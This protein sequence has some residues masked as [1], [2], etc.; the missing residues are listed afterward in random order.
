MKTLYIGSNTEVIEGLKEYD[1]GNLVFSENGL[2]AINILKKDTEIKAVICQYDLTG[3]D[4][5]YIYNQIR[6]ELKIQNIPFVLLANEHKPQLYKE[7]FDKKIDDYFVIGAT[8]PKNILLRVKQLVRIYKS[9][10]AVKT[11]PDQEKYNYKFPLSKRI[12]DI[13]VASFVLLLLSPLLLIIIIAIRLESKGKVYYIS[14]RVGRKQFD[15]YKLRSMKVGADKLLKELAKEKNQYNAP[16]IK[17]EKRELILCPVCNQYE[18]G[19]QCT[20]FKYD[21]KKQICENLFLKQKELDSKDNSSFIKI[22]D[23]PRITKVGKFIRNTSI[24]ELP[25]LINVLKGDM[26]LVGNRPLPVYEA[27]L[28][29]G[30]NASKRFLAPAGITGLWQVELRGKGGEMSEE[31]RMALDNHYADYFVGKKYSLWFD[32]KILLRTVPALFQKSTV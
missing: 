9:T 28:I 5:I 12:F 22:V 24:D 2:K 17:T 10:N 31:E 4:G 11:I 6:N 21:G 18:E 32:I 3:N 8:E 27:E 14:Q 1:D 30:D 13:V 25:Q 29:T 20:S 15:F 26:S 16:K 7:A 19:E 23:D